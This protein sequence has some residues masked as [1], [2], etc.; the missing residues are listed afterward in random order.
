MNSDGELVSFISILTDGAVYIVD[1]IGL[2]LLTITSFLL[3]NMKQIKE[4]RT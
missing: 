2:L 3:H 4:I 1:D